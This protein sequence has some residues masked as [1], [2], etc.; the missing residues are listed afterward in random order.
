MRNEAVHKLTVYRFI[1]HHQLLDLPHVSWL[2]QLGPDLD[3][4]LEDG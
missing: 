4:D 2:F 3:L 1:V